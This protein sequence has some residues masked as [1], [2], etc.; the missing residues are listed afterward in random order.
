MSPTCF[1]QSDSGEIW[2]RVATGLGI[3]T[4][5]AVGFN[6]GILLGSSIESF[7]SELASSVKKTKLSLKLIRGNL[8]NVV[9]T[10]A[11]VW[12]AAGCFPLEKLKGSSSGI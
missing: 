8:M 12:L 9:F 2:F 10:S 5:M 3:G 4:K 7:L 11:R 6:R 1:L